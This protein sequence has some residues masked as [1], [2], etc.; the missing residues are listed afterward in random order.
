MVSVRKS[1]TVA[2]TV[3][4][5]SGSPNGE[6]VKKA[7][8]NASRMMKESGFGLKSNVE[9]VID[10]QLPF[11]GYTMPDQVAPSSQECSKAYWFTRCHTFTGWRI[12]THLMTLK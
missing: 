3:V 12:I 11:M 5:T 1:T 9:V 7:Y 8:L 6:V 2:K 10:P 4:P